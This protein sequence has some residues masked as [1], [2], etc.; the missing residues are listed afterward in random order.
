MQVQ[1]GT[2]SYGQ[3]WPEY[4]VFSFQGAYVYNIDLTNGFTLKGKITHLSGDEYLKAGNY[5]YNSEKDIQR[6]LYINDTLYTLSQ[7]L[8]KANNIGALSELNKLGIR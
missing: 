2:D 4:G 8:I 3:S 6:I 1:D 5:W 7:G